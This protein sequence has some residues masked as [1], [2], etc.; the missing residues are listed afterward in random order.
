MTIAAILKKVVTPIGQ[1]IQPLAERPILELD[2]QLQQTGCLASVQIR[3][4]LRADEHDVITTT[5]VDYHAPLDYLG[6]LLHCV[7]PSQVFYAP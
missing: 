3:P 7:T 2:R 6:S 1:A 4:L 5:A